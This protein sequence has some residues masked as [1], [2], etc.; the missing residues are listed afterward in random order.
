VGTGWYYSVLGGGYSR[1]E[2]FPVNNTPGTP[3]GLD[4]TAMSGQRGDF[5]VSTLFN[6]NFDVNTAW[7][8]PTDPIP[9]WVFENNSNL[10]QNRLK[11]WSNSDVLPANSPDRT[12]Y[13]TTIDN[14]YALEL[15]NGDSLVHNPFVLTDWGSLRFNLLTPNLSGGTLNIQIQETGTNNWISLHPIQIQRSQD[16]LIDDGSGNLIP[17]PARPNN[18]GYYDFNNGVYD[19][20]YTYTVSYGQRGFETFVLDLPDNLEYLRGRSVSLRFTSN[21]NSTIYLDDVFFKS[22]HLLLGNP[23]NARPSETANRDNYLIEKPQYSLSYNDDTKT[24]NWVSYYHNA[25]WLGAINRSD[26]NRPPA[27]TVPYVQRFPIGFDSNY[28]NYPNNQVNPIDGTYSPRSDRDNSLENGN[29]PWVSDQSLPSNWIKTQGPDY[30]INNRIP[31]SRMDRGH[32]VASSERSRTA[33]DNL[34]TF[35]TTNLLPQISE[36]NQIGGAWR[37]LEVAID[38]AVRNTSNPTQFYIMAG[39]ANYNL[40]RVDPTPYTS[41]HPFYQHPNPVPGVIRNLVQKEIDPDT[42]ELVFRKD[43]EGRII[44]GYT[45]PSTSEW[46]V[47]PKKIGIPEFTWKLIV[48]LNPG[49]GIA[50]IT[51]ETS[52]TAV[53]IPSVDTTLLH[54][55]QFTLPIP[56]GR[57]LTISNPGDWTQYVVSLNELEEITGYTFLSEVPEFIRNQLKQN[58]NNTGIL[59]ASL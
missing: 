45:N 43:A 57:T 20:P 26:T 39:G 23:T 27:T 19:D 46:I 21:A 51:S 58:P 42:G 22:Q 48:N 11:L 47:N 44:T 53:L 31:E 56:N 34:A 36:A 4:N 28:P 50:D 40:D 10:G 54:N 15:H 24:A 5:A 18:V 1:W 25:T 7:R 37:N 3:M 12:T 32:L 6:G 41:D 14:N 8:K 52:V 17:N 38:R 35:L 16:P 59:S 13:N 9:G 55:N 29:Y 2:Q 30:S 33:K 49:Q